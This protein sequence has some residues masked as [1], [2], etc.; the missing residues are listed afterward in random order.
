MHRTTSAWSRAALCLAL[1]P[2]ARR[3]DAHHRPDRRHRQ[4][5][6]RRRDAQ[7][8]RSILIDTGDGHHRRNQERSGRQLRL[9]QPAA[10]HLYADGH[11][12]GLPAGHPAAVDRPD[13]AL[14]R[15]RR[16]VPGAG[17]AP[18]SAGR[19]ARPG[20]ETSSTTVANTVQ[21]RRDREAAAGRPQHPELRAARAGQRRTS[22]GARDSEYNGLPGGAINIT[23]DGVNNNSQRFRSGGTSFFV[24][25]AHPARRGRRSHG[26][27]GRADGRGR[28][29]RR[30]AGSVRRPNAAPT[31]SAARSSTRSRTKAERPG[32]GQQGA[33]TSRKRSCASTSTA[34]ISADRS[35]ATSCSSSAT[36]SRSTRPARPCWIADR[37]DAGGADRASSATTPPIR[38]SGRSTC[39]T[40]RAANGLPGDRRSVHR[41][42]VAAW[43]TP[44]SA[45]ADLAPRTALHEHVPVHQPELAERQ[46]LS[47]RRAS[48][49]RHHRRWRFAASL[50]LHYRDLP[51]N[52]QFPG[53]SINGG[54]TST[55][56]IS[57]RGADWTVRT[58]LFNRLTVGYSEQLRGVQSREPLAI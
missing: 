25:R 1:P 52:P 9:P 38:R 3:A 4:R 50:N 35:S 27:D 8:S 12:H 6:D 47:N 32:V 16:A 14:H 7:T 34:P 55:Y 39:S 58:N 53:G 54:F 23:L 2:S 36:T 51:R 45:R 17:R 40:S 10:G 15:R 49:I 41:A 5:R 18:S 29:R 19:G 42:A 33:R 31:R 28:R 11:R 46:L 43:R 13:V 56:Y 48:T 22:A 57:R 21:Q 44:R 37:A 30:G 20:V 24:V 26:L